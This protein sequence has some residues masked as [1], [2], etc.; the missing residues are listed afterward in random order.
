MREEKIFYSSALSFFFI[1]NSFALTPCRS[2]FPL[3]TRDL[4]SFLVS[5]T[6]FLQQNVLWA[7]GKVSQLLPTVDKVEFRCTTIMSQL[8][9]D[10]KKRKRID[11]KFFIKFVEL[12]KS[13]F[14]HSFKRRLQPL[15]QRV[16]HYY[17][18][19][20][21]IPKV[22]SSR[23]VNWSWSPIPSPFKVQEFENSDETTSQA[24]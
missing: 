24:P 22:W 15:R 12:R 3:L 9:G 18:D 17:F 2:F 21:K 6:L 10:D 20:F 23:H 4:Q 1:T 16:Q 19:Y 8:R 7:R 5:Q 14:Q 13:L 11:E